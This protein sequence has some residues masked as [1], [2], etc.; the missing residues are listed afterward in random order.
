MLAKKGLKFSVD[1]APD[2]LEFESGF[3]VSYF[4]K[5]LFVCVLFWGVILQYNLCN[6]RTVAKTLSF[7]YLQTSVSSWRVSLR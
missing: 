7:V 1:G 4:S 3:G 5:L 6:D 2:L